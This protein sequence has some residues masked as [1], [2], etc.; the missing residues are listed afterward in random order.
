MFT[1][2]AIKRKGDNA[3]LILMLLAIAIIPALPA[4]ALWAWLDP[5]GFWQRFIFV[6]IYAFGIYPTLLALEIFVFKLRD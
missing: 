4:F 1:Y 5:T 2:R 6:A 3:L